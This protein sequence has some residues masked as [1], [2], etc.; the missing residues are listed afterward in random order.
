MNK[1]ETTEPPQVGQSE[2]TDELDVDAE[3]IK[4]K[5]R[6]FGRT[7]IATF[8]AISLA[9]GMSLAAHNNEIVWAIA[10]TIGACFL[11]CRNVAMERAGRLTP[12]RHLKSCLSL[13]NCNHN[14]N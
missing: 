8:T 4:A 9:K 6:D 3:I 14:C 1:N 13:F 10:L 12:I 7:V 2:L 11:D 5:R